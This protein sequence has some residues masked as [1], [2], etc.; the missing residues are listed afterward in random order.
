AKPQ[1]GA[2]AT[3]GQE[4]GTGDRPSV[5]AG[6]SRLCASADPKLW[7]RLARSKAPRRY[8]CG[9]LQDASRVHKPGAGCNSGSGLLRGPRLGQG[10]FA[11]RA[12]VDMGSGLLSCGG[13][14][15]PNPQGSQIDCGSGLLWGRP[16]WVR[17]GLPGGQMPGAMLV[18]AARD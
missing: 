9:A 17:A 12:Q 2:S 8:A 13:T 15:L 16:G 18:P 10:R 5:G 6:T 11:G 14:S 1:V 3:E 7:T 4:G